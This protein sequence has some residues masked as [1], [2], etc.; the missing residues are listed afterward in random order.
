MMQS[1]VQV[2]ERNGKRRMHMKVKHFVRV[3]EL[4]ECSKDDAVWKCAIVKSPTTRK[5]H[6]RG[7]TASSNVRTCKIM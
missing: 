4:D 3:N 7:F 1:A 5:T 6:C 2:P